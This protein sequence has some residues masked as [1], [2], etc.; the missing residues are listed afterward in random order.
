MVP[1]YI[2]D[3][4]CLSPNKHR[5]KHRAVRQWHCIGGSQPGT[6]P[7][8][9]KGYR[10]QTLPS[11]VRLMGNIPFPCMTGHY[12]HVRVCVHAN[13]LQSCPTLCDPMACSPPG[14]SVHGIFQERILERAAMPSSWGSSQ[15]RDRIY[16]SYI[17]CIGRWVLYHHVHLGSP[18]HTHIVI[19][20]I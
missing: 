14:S 13:S 10:T 11:A 19:V 3:V 15:P 1:F 8:D 12:I 4:R 17:F 2:L 20:F 6:C 9:G 7:A 18:L 5:L 16:I